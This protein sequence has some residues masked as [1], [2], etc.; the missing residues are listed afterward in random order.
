MGPFP[1]QG[2]VFNLKC[3]GRIPY[4][5]LVAMSLVL[6]LGMLY[7]GVRFKGYRPANNIEWLPAGEG[8]Y[9]KRFAISYTDDFFPSHNS[10][11]ENGGMALRMAFRSMDSSLSNFR[12][13]LSVY[14]GDD[15]RQLLIGQ[16]RHW[17]II[18]N[19][20][21][22]DGK[23]GTA[24]VTVDIGGTELKSNL[25]II[26]SGSQGT[27]V[28][29]NG[30]LAK[31]NPNL[32]LFYPYQPQRTRL[33]LGNSVYG[34]HSWHGVL[35]GLA[36]Y[37]AAMSD[38]DIAAHNSHW[39]AGMNF[40]VEGNLAPKIRYG[41]DQ[42]SVGQVQ[43][44]AGDAYALQLPEWMIILKKEILGWPQFSNNMGGT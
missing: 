4:S 9:F 11:D 37:D 12:Y 34:R 40:N 17:L 6:L 27:D 5:I 8:L 13:I 15:R 16:W 7:F 20:A 31:S 44:R 43:N 30:R 36:L 39:A 22:Y 2:A 38:T 29:L 18:M 28:Y 41:F 26:R 25:L 1:N 24:K 19:G 33:I 14:A 3:L 42:P 32:Q 23:R 21:D 10:A 35:Y